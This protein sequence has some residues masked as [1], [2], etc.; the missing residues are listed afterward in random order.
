MGSER[1]GYEIGIYLEKALNDKNMSMKEL[2]QKT[3][4]EPSLLR[5]YLLNEKNP[6][7]TNIK[8]IATALE[9]DVDYF[10]EDTF[11]KNGE[12]RASTLRCNLMLDIDENSEKDYKKAFREMN[13]MINQIFNT[14]TFE[15]RK[16]IVEK[17]YLFLVTDIYTIS[18]DEKNPD[19]KYWYHYYSDT[20]FKEENKNMNR[21]DMATFLNMFEKLLF[22]PD[23]D[24]EEKIEDLALSTLDKAK[25]MEEN[26]KY[27]E[28]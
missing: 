2:A 21:K 13:R 8:K 3:G 7:L 18:Y 1:N 10:T 28:E 20:T 5:R 24:D 6:S 14:V 27:E 11:F 16:K 9:K 12:M 17:L 22:S 19:H 4:I 15:G 26:R 23:F 25:N